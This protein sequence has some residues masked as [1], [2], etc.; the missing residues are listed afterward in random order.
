MG[1]SGLI[2]R[3]SKVLDDFKGM[4]EQSLGKLWTW[5]YKLR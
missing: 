1:L 3:Q 5:A 4:K 2:L